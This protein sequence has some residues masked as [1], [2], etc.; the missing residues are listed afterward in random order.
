[1]R[2]LLTILTLLMLAH[3]LATPAQETAK[4]PDADYEAFTERA[5]TGYIRPAMNRFA[6]ATGALERVTGGGCTAVAP[7]QDSFTGVV[8]AW[9]GISFLRFGP[10]SADNRAER[11]HFWPDRK[12]TG[13]RQLQRALAKRDPALTD[14]QQLAEQS[15]ALQGL[16]A[17]EFLLY[18]LPVPAEEDTAAWRCKV[19]RTIATNLATIGQALVADWT[20]PEGYSARLLS[21]G[22]NNPVYRAAF[23]PA[24]EVLGSMTS[25]LQSLAQLKLDHLAP[26]ED[27]KPHPKNVAFWRSHLARVALA[28]DFAALERYT[29][30]SGLTALLPAD[31]QPMMRALS[32]EFQNAAR[33][34]DRLEHPVTEAV[35]IE[36]DQIQL[37]YL[38][39]IVEGLHTIIAGQAAPAAGLGVAF[40]AL[41]GD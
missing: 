23:E 39:R 28:A 17:L 29:E 31:D 8:R 13:L 12:G 10:L 11:I 21:P 16:G 18:G 22:A 41:D 38:R 26:S 5:I 19:I 40:T 14:P 4:L 25:A 30:E 20:D 34:I 2:P 32:I 24:N 9:S 15:V 36:E 3:P 27:G 1:M 37:R 33:S 6:E 35:S 7:I